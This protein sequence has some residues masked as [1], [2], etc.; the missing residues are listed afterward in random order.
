MVFV[1]H[2]GGWKIYATT[3][4]GRLEILNVEPG[5]YQIRSCLEECIERLVA[6][7]EKGENRI[8]WCRLPS[9]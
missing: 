4:N 9:S 1:Y 2:C 6:L 5:R 8:M 7:F 3:V